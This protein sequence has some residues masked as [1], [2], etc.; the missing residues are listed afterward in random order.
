MLVEYRT[1]KLRKYC[2]DFAAASRKFGPDNALRLQAR[3]SQLTAAASVEEMVAHHIGRCHALQG[4]RAGQYALDLAHPLRL[5]FVP[6]DDGTVRVAAIWE[7]V[8]Y[9]GKG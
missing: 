3:I 8:D 1:E 9:H 4:R 2:T 5:V 7:I 6:R